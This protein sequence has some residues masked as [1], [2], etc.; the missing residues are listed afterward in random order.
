[1]PQKMPQAPQSPAKGLASTL[2]RDDYKYLCDIILRQ[3]GLQLGVGKA[4]LLTSRLEPL[5]R[6]MGLREVSDLAVQMRAGK[7]AG[8]D[9]VVAEALA[10]HP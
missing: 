5:A 7:I 3:S 2:S 9:R 1:M 8:Q 6:T 10:T 4:C